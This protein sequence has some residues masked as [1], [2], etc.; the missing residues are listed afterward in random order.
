MKQ[1]RVDEATRGA[2][3]SPRGCQ[4]PPPPP[5]AVPRRTYC[6]APPVETANFGE[7]DILEQLAQARPSPTKAED[8]ELE[9][10]PR[11]TS[12]LH[13]EW[14]ASLIVRDECRGWTSG[15]YS[16]YGEVR[17]R[18]TGSR[19]QQQQ[20]RGS[21]IS[22]VKDV[23]SGSQAFLT[24]NVII[25]DPTARGVRWLLEGGEKKAIRY[26]GLGVSP[27]YLPAD[28]ISFST[29]D[30]R[31]LAT[32]ASTTLRDGMSAC[33][34][35]TDAGPAEH[36]QSAEKALLCTMG[37]PRDI[38]PVGPGKRHYYRGNHLV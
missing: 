26:L 15:T 2:K 29:L 31:L 20:Q 11:T 27:S 25:T 6:E 5:C 35:P 7:C 14:M 38:G 21:R 13:R 19:Q 16:V 23:A 24:G 37:Q 36:T 1:A 17:A 34:A 22:L 30:S 9:A 4:P 3:L 10:L 8:I 18:R 28:S 12:R 32:S 33:P